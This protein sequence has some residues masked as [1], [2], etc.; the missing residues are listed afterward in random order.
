MAGGLVSIPAITLTTLVVVV[1]YLYRSLYHK[2]FKRNAHLPQLP[3]SL[4]W[5]HLR[6]FDDFTKQGKTDRHP[7]KM[8]PPA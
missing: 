6:L 1:T 8:H 7:G 5:G 3:N 2:R 4:L